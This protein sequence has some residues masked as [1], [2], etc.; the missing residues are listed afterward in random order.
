VSLCIRQDLVLYDILLAY[1]ITDDTYL[2]IP[3]DNTL[4]SPA[5]LAH[6]E[7][8]AGIVTENNKNYLNCT[9]GRLPSYRNSQKYGT[10]CLPAWF[11]LCSAADRT[12][13]NSFLRRCMK[14]GYYSTS[15]PDIIVHR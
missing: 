10:Y 11:G 4:T 3:A 6:I 2:V 9:E 5:E 8:W 12:R 7:A 15:D 13:L 14:L 1:L